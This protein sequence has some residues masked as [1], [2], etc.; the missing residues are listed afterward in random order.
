MPS[1]PEA[2]ALPLSPQLLMACNQQCR[3]G[4]QGTSLLALAK[5]RLSDFHSKVWPSD[6]EEPTRN[7]HRVH[8]LSMQ[9]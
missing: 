6:L 2:C 1:P 5:P 4:T 3:A 7:Q 9:E 8:K